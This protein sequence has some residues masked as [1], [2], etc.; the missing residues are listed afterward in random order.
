MRKL[1]TTPRFELC[2]WL[3]GISIFFAFVRMFSATLYA[4]GSNFSGQMCHQLLMDFIILDKFVQ[5]LL[6]F[7][8]QN[9]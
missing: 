7:I 9:E 1:F 4:K 6:N 8:A 5:K 3:V 2:L